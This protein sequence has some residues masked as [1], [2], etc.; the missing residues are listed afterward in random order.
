MVNLGSSGGSAPDFAA[1]WRFRAAAGGPRPFV[2]FHDAARGERVELSY[3]TFGNW[4]A[5]TAN[6]VQDDLG[7]QYGDR[8]VLSAP[9]HWVTAVWAVAP[10]LAGAGVEVWGEPADALGVVSYAQ[11]DALE[12]AR[13][14]RGE[15]FALSLLPLGRPFDEVPEGFRDYAAE[16]RGFGDRFTPFTPPGPDTAAL[17]VDGRMLSHAE[18]VERARG[19]LTPT[20]RLLVDARRDRFSGA[21][22]VR[23]LFAPLMAGAAVIVVREAEP[24]LVDAIAEMERATHRLVLD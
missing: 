3:Q 19:P 6:L 21:E 2:T 15:R 11:R 17:V 18:L 4:L 7:A 20:D 1:V 10:L 8:V 5:K 24:Q 12:A 22:L 13:G 23:W 16:V 9:P 14:C